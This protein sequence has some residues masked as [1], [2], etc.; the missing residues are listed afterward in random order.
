[1]PAVCSLAVRAVTSLAKIIKSISTDNFE[2]SIQFGVSLLVY[3]IVSFSTLDTV[4]YA[5]RIRDISELLIAVLGHSFNVWLG[6]SRLAQLLQLAGC[7]SP[8]PVLRLVAAEVY[9]NTLTG[10]LTSA[11]PAHDVQWL[12]SVAIVI[13]RLV[14]PVT[15]SLASRTL[16]ILTRARDPSLVANVDKLDQLF[17]NPATLPDSALVVFA[18][19]LLHVS[20]DAHHASGVY[21]L[22]LLNSML[23]ARGSS[24]SQSESSSLVSQMFALSETQVSLQPEILECVHTLSSLHLTSS[25]REIIDEVVHGSPGTVPMFSES[26]RNAV[27]AMAREKTMLMGFIGFMSDLI[28]N[29]EPN[30]KGLAPEA[31]AAAKGLEIVLAVQD[32]L[33]A[34]MV[35]KFAAETFGTVLLFSANRDATLLTRL[36][37]TNLSAP[38]TSPVGIPAMLS[39]FADAV[40]E[41]QLVAL[42]RF[43][44]PFLSRNELGTVVENQ[45]RV[46]RDTLCWLIGNTSKVTDVKVVDEVRIALER[47]K[48][49]QGL[50]PLFTSRRDIFGLNEINLAISHLVEGSDDATIVQCLN[51]LVMTAD[52]VA[53]VDGDPEWKSRLLGL[54]PVLTSVITD[55]QSPDPLIFDG[56]LRLVSS[57]CEV[58]AF[59]SDTSARAIFATAISAT[60]MTEIGIRSHVPSS[61]ELVGKTLAKLERIAPKTYSHSDFQTILSKY[62]DSRSPTSADPAVVDGA[63]RLAVEIANQSTTYPGDRNRMIRSLIRFVRIRKRTVLIDKSIDGI[64]DALADVQSH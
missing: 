44:L 61:S 25:L 48:S 38:V 23:L 63:A 64:I 32:T 43:V 12:E 55:R 21:V 22:Q 37:L 19:L 8:L 36:V 15:T 6:I 31:V 10:L 62:L 41:S 33:V 17:I 3:G 5:D 34:A 56:V 58:Y 27:T 9:L 60:L 59:T 49:V 13:P 14:D 46:A 2:K 54:G 50:G 20:T 24:I 51:V 45:Q 42:G 30:E 4:E 47:V 57:L 11:K 26:Q 28:N 52:A 1:M 16:T 7:S 29:A 18:Q 53:K 39:A 35:R 40:D